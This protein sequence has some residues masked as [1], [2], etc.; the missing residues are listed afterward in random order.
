[1]VIRIHTR[2]EVRSRVTSGGWTIVWGP[3]ATESRLVD[4]VIPGKSDDIYAWVWRETENQLKQFEQDVSIVCPDVVNQTAQFLSRIFDHKH[5]GEAECGGLAVK[6]GTIEYLSESNRPNDNNSRQSIWQSYFGLRITKPL[7][8]S[9]EHVPRTN[10][11]F[12]SNFWYKIRSSIEPGRSLDVVNDGNQMRDGKLKVATNGHYSGQYWQLRP[13]NTTPTTYKLRTMWLGCDMYL[14]TYNEAG[15]RPRLAPA[16]SSA[17]QD[18]LIDRKEDGTYE[19]SV[20]NCSNRVLVSDEN[21]NGVEMTFDR[22]S[23]PG[24]I[25]QRDKP[26]EERWR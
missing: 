3:P 12:L 17:G 11:A 7:P 15:L 6:A 20:A 1:M 23:K 9:N 24:W 14:T 21:G 13:S 10:G 16:G 26:I 19:L 25:L 4:F 18:W 22:T 5:S 8:T 2:D